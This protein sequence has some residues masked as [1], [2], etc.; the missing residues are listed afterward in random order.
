MKYDT[1]GSLFVCEGCIQNVGL[2]S[3]NNADLE[4][5]PCHP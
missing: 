4:Q 5:I 3:L 1:A 2:A